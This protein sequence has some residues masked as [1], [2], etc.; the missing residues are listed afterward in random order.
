MKRFFMKKVTQQYPEVKP[1]FYSLH[2]F[3]SQRFRRGAFQIAKNMAS[4]G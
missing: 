2:L 4:V 3:R 1:T